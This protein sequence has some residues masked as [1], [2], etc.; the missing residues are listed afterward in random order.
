MGDKVNENKLIQENNNIQC[1][2]NDIK[3]QKQVNDKNSNT[4]NVECYPQNILNFQNE[5]GE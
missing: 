5:N 3:F 1:N 2:N 4:N